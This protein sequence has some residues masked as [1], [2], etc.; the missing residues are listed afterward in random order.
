[1]KFVFL[2]CDILQNYVDDSCAKM[3]MFSCYL[4]P[5]LS[6]SNLEY[7]LFY[8]SFNQTSSL[9]Q[10]ECNNSGM[11]IP[12]YVKCLCLLNEWLYHIQFITYSLRILSNILRK[13]LMK[14]F[15]L[16]F[17]FIFMSSREMGIIRFSPRYVR[18]IN[19]KS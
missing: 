6:M 19:L 12:S 7:F 17:N 2:L 13:K 14:I 5:T 8:F 9:K 10:D 4:T 11:I 15:I 18:L 1:M 16:M 3:C